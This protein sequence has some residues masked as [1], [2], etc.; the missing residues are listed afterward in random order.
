MT[1]PAT[2]TVTLLFTD[3]EGST[4][5]LRQLRGAY[6]EVL[7]EHQRLLRESLERHG[8]QEVDTQG[9]SFFVAFTRATD[10]VLAAVD[11]QRALATHVWPEGAELRVRMGLHTG[12]AMVRDNRFVGMAV[13]RAARICTAG[14][15]GQILLSET[16]RA[17]LGNQLPEGVSVVDLGEQNLKDIQHERVLQL[18]FG[19][20]PKEFPPLKTQAKKSSSDALAERI[21]RHVEEMVEKSLTGSLSDKAPGLRWTII[22]L[23][24]LLLVVVTIV[25]I[26]WLVRHVL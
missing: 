4:R 12:S 13:H 24:E 16:T 6:G 1:G 23:A 26:I 15:G 7:A 3:V 22:G 21:E 10:A 25:A 19:D 18:S 20:G 5:L 8:G 11:A 9:D 14:H 17:L 2:A